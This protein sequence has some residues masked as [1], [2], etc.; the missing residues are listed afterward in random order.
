MQMSSMSSLSLKNQN[1][2]K[3][4]QVVQQE[5]HICFVVARFRPVSID[6]IYIDYNK[7]QDLLLNLENP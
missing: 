4:I 2:A 5:S 6:I 7:A 3:M 1:Q